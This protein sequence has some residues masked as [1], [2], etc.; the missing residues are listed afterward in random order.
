MLKRKALT[1]S[2]SSN[3]HAFLKKIG[4][5]SESFELPF[6]G[7]VNLMKAGASFHVAAMTADPR[8]V[9]K[10]ER[11]SLLDRLASIHPALVH[12]LEEEVVDPYHPHSKGCNTPASS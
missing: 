8:I 2:I 7:I 1:E 10:Q 3:L 4:A 12:N 5:R 11:Q 6:K 9:T